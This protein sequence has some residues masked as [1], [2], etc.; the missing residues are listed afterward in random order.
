MEVLANARMPIVILTSL[1]VVGVYLCF[2]RTLGKHA[3]IVAA[4]LL[5]LDPFYVGMS[6]TL[7]LDTLQSTFALLSV[8]SL[9]L[10]LTGRGRGWFAA[11]GVVAGLAFLSK[12]VAIVLVPLFCVA[13]VVVYVIQPKENRRWKDLLIGLLISYAA[14]ILTVFIVYPAMWVQPI[15]RSRRFSIRQ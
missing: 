15:R 3:T 2:R 9:G 14:V 12:S 8:L 5:A 4:L 6:R 13:S 11:A 10:A 7:Q 1:A